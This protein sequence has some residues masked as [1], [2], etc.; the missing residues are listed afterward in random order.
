MKAFS[1]QTFGLTGLRLAVQFLA[2]CVLFC[3]GLSGSAQVVR[4]FNLVFTTNKLGD[5]A[6]IG[7]TLHTSL[8]PAVRNH[9]A[10]TN[11]LINNENFMVRVDV[12]SDTN[13]FTSS[14]A[15][16]SLPSGGSVMFA[17]LYWGAGTNLGNNTA[18]GARNA[19]LRG[20]VLLSFNGGA[21]VSITN[22]SLLA[23]V[24]RQRQRPRRTRPRRDHDCERHRFPQS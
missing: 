14:S 2:T 19:G 5:I 22:T 18:S 13:M 1:P 3:P 12:D 7:N 20:Q 10:A 4:P 11:L 15:D 24:H 23:A 21:Y 8:N 17:K 9:S 6:I 16:F